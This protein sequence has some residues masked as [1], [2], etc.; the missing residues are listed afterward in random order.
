MQDKKYPPITPERSESK[1]M[2]ALARRA[3]D[4]RL[5]KEDELKKSMKID[6]PLDPD[7]DWIIKNINGKMVLSIKK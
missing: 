6:I 4:E 1:P 2:G 5:R 3:E 7:I